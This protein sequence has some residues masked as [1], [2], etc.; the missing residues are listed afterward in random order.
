MSRFSRSATVAVAVTA[1]LA[2][3]AGSAVADDCPNYETGAYAGF[4]SFHDINLG[5][6]A[7]THWPNGPTHSSAA[8][9]TH[10]DLVIVGA[11]ESESDHDHETKLSWSKT[12]AA[13]VGVDLFHILPELPTPDIFSLTVDAFSAKCVADDEGIAGESSIAGSD[14]KLTVLGKEYRLPVST[15][16][17]F[18]I[19]IPGVASLTLNK[20]WW[21][22]NGAFNVQAL[23]FRAD[24][25]LETLIGGHIRLSLAHVACG[26]HVTLDPQAEIGHGADRQAPTGREVV[27]AA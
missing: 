17:N 3:S 22:D 10:H 12:S 27:V 2:V 11:F 16:P 23:D 15:E 13:K 8:G 5:P 7:S 21:D 1:L 4:A 9:N 18:R 20:Q 19:S 26:E 24:P 25:L 6:L 14:I